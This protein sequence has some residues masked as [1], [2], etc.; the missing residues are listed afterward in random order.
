M[1]SGHKRVANGTRA[2]SIQI[3][4][5]MWNHHRSVTKQNGIA[6]PA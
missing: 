3:N 1:P 2:S 6:R 4:D 5:Q